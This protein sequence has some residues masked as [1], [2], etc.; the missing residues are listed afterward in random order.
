M[1]PHCLFDSF[2]LYVDTDFECLSSHAPFHIGG[3]WAHHID[4]YTGFSNTGAVELNNGLIASVA[5]HALVGNLIQ[6]MELQPPASSRSTG[7]GSSNN[8]SAS[9]L[10]GGGGGGARSSVSKHTAT[11]IINGSGPA[12][13]TRTCVKYLEEW[14][15]K[16]VDAAPTRS[17]SAHGPPSLIPPI[18]FFPTQVFYPLP[19]NMRHLERDE[20]K[21][22]FV[23][24]CSF[25]MHHWSCSWQG[26]AEAA[27]T[28]DKR[29]GAAESATMQSLLRSLESLQG[30]AGPA[31]STTAAPSSAATTSP[32]AASSSSATRPA[33]K[34]SSQ[35]ASL[36]NSFDP[37]L[38]GKIASF[39][40]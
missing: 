28:T 40:K 4:F 9:A 12:H 18:V 37:A 13:F 31:S 20:D 15:A 38:L 7:S 14:Q 22:V 33:A 24:P 10:G 21:R 34:L 19:N 2:S 5:Q 25:A 35:S 36:A 39:L 6:A 26:S 8:N 16:R 32:S 1:I 27:S 3:A 30:G 23:A 11:E 17:L 29:K